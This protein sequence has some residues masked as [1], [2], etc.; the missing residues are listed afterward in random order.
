MDSFPI[1][2]IQMVNKHMKTFIL[3]SSEMQVK[4]IRCLRPV[5][6][7]IIQKT[8]NNKKRRKG[9]AHALLVKM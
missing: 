3:I 1:A 5:R 6:M 9:N 4:I 7:A 8:R 2:D